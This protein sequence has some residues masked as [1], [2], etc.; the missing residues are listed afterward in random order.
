MTKLRTITLVVA[1]CHSL[2]GCQIV[3]QVVDLFHTSESQTVSGEAPLWSRLSTQGLAGTE[4]HLGEVLTIKQVARDPIQV[5]SV[6]TDGNLITWDLESGAGSILKTLDSPCQLAALGENRSLVACAS[7]FSVRVACV[8]GCTGQW[9]LT[10]LK[11]RTTSIAFHENDSALLIGGADGRVYR[12][13]FRLPETAETL[14]EQE[15][16]LE[17][18]IAHQTIVTQV[19][20]LHTARAFFSA[21][22]D[23]VLYGWLA[24]TADDQQGSF[25]K[26]LFGGRFFGD[27]GTYLRANRATD[28]GITAL[29]VSRD[30]TRLGL[31]TEDGAIEIWE[32]RGFLLSA[33][34]PLHS[35]RVTGIALNNDG[36]RVAS[37]GRDGKINVSQVVPD[38]LFGIKVDTLPTHLT[39]LMSEEMRGAS[40]IYFLSSGNAIVTTLSGKLGE[41]PVAAIPAPVETPPAVLTNKKQ[42]VRDS[43]Y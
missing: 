36:T 3:G 11:T 8:T 41:I 4:G 16:I 43:D 1:L 26:N 13:R 22:W 19:A 14:R 5:L 10:K 25:D 2:A 37:V 40:K 20:P 12:W 39:Q 34:A 18:Y 32:V 28:R 7:G 31:G 21:D 38:P 9:E 15:K 23:G 27:I 6:G 24:Y 29:T 35:G 42:E 17:R 33:R 30:G